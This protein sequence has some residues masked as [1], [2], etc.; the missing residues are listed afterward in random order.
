MKLATFRHEDK[1]S[2]G[3][4]LGGRILDLHA[5][6]PEDG[7]QGALRERGSRQHREHCPAGIA[8]PKPGLNRTKRDF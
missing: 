2:V 8:P 3:L 5:A 6:L 4:V 1:T 7:L